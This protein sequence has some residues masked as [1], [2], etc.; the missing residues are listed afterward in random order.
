MSHGGPNISL[1]TVD[2]NCF[3]AGSCY[4]SAFAG[5]TNLYCYR[6][7]SI[8][9]N[10]GGNSPS[11]NAAYTRIPYTSSFTKNQKADGGTTTSGF[12]TL[13]SVLQNGNTSIN[14][15]VGIGTS[16]INSTY[17]L[18][19]VAG[20]YTTQLRLEGASE[21]KALSTGGTGSLSTQGS[22]QGV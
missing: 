2:S 11:G 22:G 12:T 13:F 14:G 9:L 18:Q 4:Y 10:N 20:S 17:G 16:S 8:N 6:G 3:S 5:D 21:I 19:I 15:C 7:C 1:A